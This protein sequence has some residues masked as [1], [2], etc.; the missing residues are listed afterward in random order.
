MSAFL[1][2]SVR[3]GLPKGRMQE[4]VFALLAEAGVHVRLGRRAYRPSIDLPGF[5]VKLLKP[6][7]I[8]QMLAAGSRDVGFAGADWVEEHGVELVELLDTG[9]DPVRIVAAA[10]REL[11][12]SGE[13][14]DRHL[15]IASEYQALTTRWIEERGLDATFVRSFGATEAFPPEDADCIV[16]NT[17]TGSTLAANN[18][19]I[20]DELMTSSTRFYASPR[21]LEDPDRKAAIDR[22][23]LLL[24]SV[25]EARS[26][27]MVE[28]NVSGQDLERVIDALPSMREPTVAQL[29]GGSG[30][31]VKAAVLREDL[32]LLIPELKARGGSD[33]VVS[34][35]AQIVR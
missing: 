13:L 29:H 23:V 25:L 5:D 26:R 4:G 17:A 22:L 33:L 15:Q 8:V 11:A 34:S 18:L 30:Y 9:L 10:P 2:T 20:V 31:A 28:L 24:R 19:L 3:L 16:D 12:P 21:A 7:N 14:P 27:F 35:P 32:P 6:Q 1:P